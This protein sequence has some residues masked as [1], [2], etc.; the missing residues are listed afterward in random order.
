MGTGAK[1]LILMATLSFASMYALMYMMVNRFANVHPNLNQLYMAAIM[2]APMLLIEIA[3]MREMYKDRRT[4]AIVIA[5]SLAALIVFSFF[6]RRQVAISDREFLKSM[7]PHHGAAVLM[8]ERLRADDPEIQEL[9]RGIIASQQ[10]EIDWMTAKL[11]A[12][13]SE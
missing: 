8:C 2:T 6:I 11:K 7:I 12:L 4:N 9:C 10:A 13:E 3:V 1:N 5:S